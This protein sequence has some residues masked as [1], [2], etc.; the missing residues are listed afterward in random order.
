MPKVK[1]IVNRPSAR[2]LVMAAHASV[3]TAGVDV[4]LAED[5]LRDEVGEDLADCIKSLRAIRTT[6]GQMP[7]TTPGVRRIL[8]L[9]TASLLR[10]GAVESEG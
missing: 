7:G 5:A 4:A 10:C 6:A 8:G 3:L 1:R 2:Q 9:A